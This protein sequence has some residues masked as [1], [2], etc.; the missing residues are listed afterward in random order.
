VYISEHI[1][2]ENEQEKDSSLVPVL[3]S[4]IWFC[5]CYDHWHSFETVYWK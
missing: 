4:K 3:T 1:S 5:D 2:S